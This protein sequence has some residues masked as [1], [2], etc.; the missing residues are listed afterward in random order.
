MAITR[1]RVTERTSETI[2][3]TI[4]DR[5]GDLVPAESLTAASLTLYDVDTFDASVSPVEGVLNERY[6]QDVLG[7]GSPFE[8]NDVTVYD[9]LQTDADGTTYNFKWESQADDHPIVTVRKELER[10]RA[11]FAFTWATGQARVEFE[12]EV[13]NMRATA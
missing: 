5:N 8:A 7:V 3:G 1:I 9:E 13:L 11:M 10:H 6:Q 4:V 12:L 2:V